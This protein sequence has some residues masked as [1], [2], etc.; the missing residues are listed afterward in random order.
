MTYCDDFQNPQILQTGEVPV[1][2][3]SRPHTE[4]STGVR[5]KAAMSTTKH[6]LILEIKVADSKNRGR[7]VHSCYPH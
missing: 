3:I 1:G 2:C 5:S 4:H 6:V 7:T